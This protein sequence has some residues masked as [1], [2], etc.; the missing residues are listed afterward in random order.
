MKKNKNIYL[1]IF[2]LSSILV[3]SCEDDDVNDTV[4][5]FDPEIGFRSTSIFSEI[6]EGDTAFLE[7]VIFSDRENTSAVN[8]SWDITGADTRSGSVVIPANSKVASFFI[9][10]EENSTVDGERTITLSL[11]TDSGIPLIDGDRSSFTYSLIDDLKVFSLGGRTIDTVE[12]NENIATLQLV[13]DVTSSVDEDVMVTIEADSESSATVMDDYIFPGG[14][15]FE[16]R[17]GTAEPSIF[18]D[19]VNNNVLNTAERFLQINLLDVAGS[20]EVS[21]QDVDTLSLNTVV[22]K[23]IDDIKTFQ[24]DRLDPEVPVNDDTLRITSAGTYR[25]STSLSG[26]N[27]VGVTSLDIDATNVEPSLVGRFSFS[28]VNENGII[29]YERGERSKDVL[30]DVDASAFDLTGSNHITFTLAGVT[31]NVGDEAE[32]VLVENENSLVVEIVGRQP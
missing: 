2:L 4:P 9:P 12:V 23:I 32:V 11:S 24:I 14:T 16:I 1:F 20:A 5:R 15:T 18:V 22:V 13:L 17:S 25:F 7:V 10:N 28:S 6:E 27:V 21:L 30:F 19:L 26:A 31:S 3:V 8:V 29:Q